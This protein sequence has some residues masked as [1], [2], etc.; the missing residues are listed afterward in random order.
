MGNAESVDYHAEGAGDA[1]RDGMKWT[2]NGS[3]AIQSGEW[4]IS[5]A[6]V[7]AVPVYTLWQGNKRMGN[8]ATAELAKGAAK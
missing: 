5:K 6:L 1:G 7:N 4:T 3:H 2:A 8:F